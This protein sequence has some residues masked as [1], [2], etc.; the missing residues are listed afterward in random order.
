MTEPDA[1]ASG[2]GGVRLAVDVGT[3]RVGVAISD[4]DGILATPLGTFA[5]DVKGASD[6][7]RLATVVAQHSVVEVVVG[8]PRSL[9]GREGAAATAAR[10]Y[11]DALASR[12]RPVPVRLHDERFSSVSAQRVLTERGVST[13]QSRAIIDQVAAVTILQSYLDARPRRSDER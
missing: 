5:R 13:R 2:R 10:Q 6:L 9:S 8:L 12:I 4:P 3:V 7:E 11:A 1:P